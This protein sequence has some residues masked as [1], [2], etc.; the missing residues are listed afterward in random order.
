MYVC[1]AFSGQSGFHIL[2]F[3][4]QLKL[5]KTIY[6][7]EFKNKSREQNLSCLMKCKLK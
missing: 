6:L 3:G 2:W 1:S 4:D 5:R 7:N